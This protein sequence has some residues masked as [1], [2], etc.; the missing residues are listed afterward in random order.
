MYTSDLLRTTQTAEAITAATGVPAVQQPQLR[1][2]HLGVIQGLTYREAEV[3]MPEA[4]RAL[5]SHSTSER[6][7]GGGESAEDLQDRVEAALNAIARAHPGQRV[8]VVSH[9]GFLY[10]AHRRA[11][12]HAPASKS[13]NGALNVIRID[14]SPEGSKAPSSWAVVCWGV[15]DHLQDVGYSQRSFGGGS[16]G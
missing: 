15:V 3:Q 6:I 11:T 5:M 10:A 13:I 9:G 2:R 4:Y 14:P 7:P 1:E 12:G 8:L 16:K